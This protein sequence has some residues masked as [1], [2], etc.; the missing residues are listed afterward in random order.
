MSE[1]SFATFGALFCLALVAGTV[2]AMAGGGGLLTVPG[3]L[4]SGLDPVSAF[5]TNKLQAIFSSLSAAL[6]FWRKGKIKPRD[7]LLPA[8]AAFIGG[9]FG[10]VSL[11]LADPR[12]LKTYV[13]FLLIAIA[14]WILCSPKLGDVPRKARLSFVAASL[15]LIPLIAFYDGFMGPGTGAFFAL[16]AVA[17]LG[18]KLDEAT[19]RAKI[20]NLMSNAGSLIFFI[21]AGHVVWICGCVMAVGMMIGGNIGARLVLRHGT[22]LIKPLL[23][24]MSLAMS[25]KLLWQQGTLQYLLGF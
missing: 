13:P 9:L 3:L 7:H 19:V 11:S 22:G 18:V 12:T 6:H 16:S 10:A 17:V 15:T 24:V 14:I 4:A 1:I 25:A 23:V 8:L 5:A 20:Y 2:D 21:W